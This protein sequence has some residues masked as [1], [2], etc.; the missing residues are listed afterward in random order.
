MLQPQLMPYLS[1]CDDGL[2]N[3]HFYPHA[4]LPLSGTAMDSSPKTSPRLPP[5][6]T[7]DSVLNGHA[8][9]PSPA[10]MSGA[11]EPIKAEVPGR[12]STDPPRASHSFGTS[13]ALQV[14][15]SSHRRTS[16]KR[17]SHPPPAGIA[18]PLA[19]P[20]KAVAPPLQHRHTLEVPRVS[21]SRTSQ[22]HYSPSSAQTEPANLLNG[23]ASPTTPKERRRASL[24]LARRITKS[25]HSDQHLEDV[26]QDEDDSRWAEHVRQKRASRRRR[27]EEEDDDRVVVGTK[28]D[29]HHVNW[30][31]AYNMLTGIR[32]TVSRTNA[33][34]R[35]GELTEAHFTAAHKF[36]F[37]M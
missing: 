33:K 25:L 1:D 18:L 16:P 23:K 21:T 26:P 30:E 10:P 32:F 24:T 11:Q 20:P 8:V 12:A 15:A 14:P 2:T 17:Y 28:V 13:S 37:D 3:T 36:S 5:L 27:K 34:I 7:S 19:P 35:R 22:D 9:L 31:T 6:K 4:K 29:Q